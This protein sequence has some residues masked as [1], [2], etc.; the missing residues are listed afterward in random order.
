MSTKSRAQ[1]LVDLLLAQGK[2]VTTVE[3]CT[4]GLIAGAITSI[5]GS[6]AVFDYGF[7]TYSNAAKTKLVGV[8]EYLLNAHGAVSIEVAASMAEGAR[9]TAGAAM[10]LS[11][12][13]IAG[14]TGGSYEKPVG[15]VCFGLSFID[16]EREPITYAQIR[17]FGNIGRDKVREASVD[18]ALNWAIETLQAS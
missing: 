18:F 14:P 15:M 16:F 1:Q 13:G 3:S 2:T 4:G 12:T 6:S 17:Q 7:V 10:A 11:V 5:S 8:P 9:K